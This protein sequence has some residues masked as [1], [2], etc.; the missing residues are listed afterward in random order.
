MCSS[1][2]C[3]VL[4]IQGIYAHGGSICQSWSICQLWCS[5]IQDIYTQLTGGMGVPLAKV[6]S[7]ARFGIAVFKA[8]ILNYP[9]GP[10]AKGGSSAK[11][12]VAVFKASM[13]NSLGGSICQSMFICQ[14]LCTGIHGKYHL[15][16]MISRFI[17]IWGVFWG[18]SRGLHMTWLYSANWL[19]TTPHYSEKK[20]N[21][22]PFLKNPKWL[23]NT[24]HNIYPH[25]AFGGGSWGYICQ[26]I[27]QDQLYQQYDI[28]S[29]ANMSHS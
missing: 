17:V 3:C 20:G 27:C 26:E 4:A 23:P 28:L 2:K 8:S 10:L 22:H 29:L 13:L 7:S 9:E 5:S 21:S 12:G 6:D 24:S 11:F 1:A 16:E 14:V 19:F 15:S 18:V 25:D